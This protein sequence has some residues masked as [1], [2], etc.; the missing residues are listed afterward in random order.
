[1]RRIAEFDHHFR[2]ADDPVEEFARLRREC[3]VARIEKY[4]GYWVISRARDVRYALFAPA[5]FAS[6]R[7]K[8]EPESIALLIPKMTRPLVVPS[9]LDP[10]EQR[11]YRRM[12]NPLFTQRSV[13]DMRPKVSA[14]TSYFLNEIAPLGKCDVVEAFASAVPACVTLEWLGLPTEHWRRYVVATHDR[15]AAAPG[16]DRFLRGVEDCNVWMRGLIRDTIAARRSVPRDDVITFLTKATI[17]DAPI[18]EDI[19]ESI[20]TVLADGGVHTTGSLVG[21]ALVHL[22]LNRHDQQELRVHPDRIRPAIEEFLRLYPPAMT[23]ART[24]TQPIA[25]GG[26]SLEPGDRVLLA[27]A[28]ANRDDEAFEDPN[29][30]C[31]AR[32]RNS[33]FSFGMGPHRCIGEHLARL[34]AEEMLGQFLARFSSF[35]LAIA[36]EDLPVYPDRA[37]FN[38]FEEIPI[39]YPVSGKVGRWSPNWPPDTGTK[40]PSGA[41]QGALTR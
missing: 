12:L 32:Q 16:S 19:V 9:E 4:D 27:W 38:G 24:V 14:W 28:S 34:L 10:P 5:I 20:V 35:D 40:A 36:A 2:P 26:V 30:Y 8:E 33:H 6:T 39:V 13:E 15:L 22:A 31:P 23:H 37:L 25:L 29:N 7:S 3:P 18:S 41:V 1:M 21:S 11:D 17:Y